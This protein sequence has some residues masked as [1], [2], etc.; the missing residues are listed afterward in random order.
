[1]AS[2][3]PDR[4]KAYNRDYYNRTKHKYHLKRVV[5]SCGGEYA[6]NAIKKHLTTE[7]HKRDLEK[8]NKLLEYAKSQGIDLTD[9][10]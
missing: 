9:Y 7:K 1:M 4:V 10:I 8:K 6:R 5:C 3:T 2:K